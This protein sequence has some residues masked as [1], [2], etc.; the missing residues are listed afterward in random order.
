M[1]KWEQWGRGRS[2]VQGWVTVVLLASSALGTEPL[3]E[4]IDR[5]IESGREGRLAAPATDGEFLRRAWLDLAGMIPTSA[6]ARA[7]LDDPSPYKRARLIDALLASPQYARRMQTVFDLMLMERRADQYVPSPQWEEFLRRAFA[8]NLPYDELVRTILSADG[9][10][11]AGRPAAKFYLDREGDPYLLTRDIGRLFL[12]RDMQCAQCHDHILIDD[13]KQ[14]HYYGLYAFLSRSY[15]V[16]NAPGG[17]VLAEKADGDVSFASVFKKKVSHTTGPRLIDAQPVAEPKVEKGQE[18]WVAPADHVRARPRFSRRSLL[19]EHLTSGE[20]PDFKRNIVN[21]LWAL[22][23]GRGLVQPLDLHHAD[24]PPSHPELLETLAAEFATSGYD[25]KSFLR[26]LASTRT[27]QR[28]SEPPPGLSPEDAAPEHFAVAV[29][30][31]LS[32]EQMAWSLMQATGIV[33]ST[34]SAVEQQILGVDPKLR[35]IARTDSKRQALSQQLVESAV[36]DRLK[37]NVRPFVSLF[38]NGPGQAQDATEATVQQALFL[39][40]GQPVENWLAPSG[41]NLTARLTAPGDPSAVAEELYL[42]FL[43]RRPTPDERS[44]VTAYLAK[45]DKDRALTVRELA[46]ALLASSEFRFNH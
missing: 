39:A 42:S 13:Y 6:D 31:P 28:A 15:L 44:E 10:D 46:W 41:N 22:L 36:H 1:P 27:Y 14:A 19:P 7:F 5:A 3:H 34:Q 20:I 17:A 38:A 43:S 24:N 30:R 8:R 9:A 33:A 4:R 35:D 2:V 12:G 40:N 18:Y 16:K 26:E 25:I 11:P 21:R 37:G 45:R 23:M 29:L 32:P